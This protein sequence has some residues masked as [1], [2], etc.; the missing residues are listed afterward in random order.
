M[1]YYRKAQYEVNVYTLDSFQKIDQLVDY[2]LEV[3][4]FADGRKN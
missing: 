2:I 1:P 3:T 4:G